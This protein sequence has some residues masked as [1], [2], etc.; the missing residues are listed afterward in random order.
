MADARASVRMD[1]IRELLS[2]S[3]AATV[4]F[5]RWSLSSVEDEPDHHVIPLPGPAHGPV[6]ALEFRAEAQR[7]SASYRFDGSQSR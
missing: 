5:V 7:R 1:E 2:R 3:I 4:R 6:P